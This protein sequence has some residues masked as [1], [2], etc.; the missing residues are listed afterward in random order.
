M[1]TPK[2]KLAA[3]AAAV[4]QRIL[5]SK[6]AQPAMVKMPKARHQIH[7]TPTD[8]IPAGTVLTSELLELAEIDQDTLDALARTGAVVMIEVLAS[9][10]AA[11]ESEA[12]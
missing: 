9:A 10:I 2:S 3:T 5:G 7:V 1:A 4:T 8:I 12:A 6:L 11:D